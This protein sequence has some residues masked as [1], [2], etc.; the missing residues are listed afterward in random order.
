M[1][2]KLYMK[3]LSNGM[4]F[5]NEI[6]AKLDKID[7]HGA[8]VN[9][10][11]KIDD[12]YLISFIIKDMNIDF[13]IVENEIVVKRLITNDGNIFTDEAT[14]NRCIDWSNFIWNQIQLLLQ[15]DFLS[16]SLKE[17]EN[18]AKN[19][20]DQHEESDVNKS[21]ISS[22]IIEE[23]TTKGYKE[24]YAVARLEAQ[25]EMTRYKKKIRRKKFLFV[26]LFLLIA[27]IG[28]TVSYLYLEE[29]LVIKRRILEHI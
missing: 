18:D 11:E 12:T 9:E 16:N 26:I 6:L 13:Q 27:V 22:K 20:S 24:G 28:I 19:K 23:A 10:F 14:L 8:K 2:T 7:L 21:E 4:S 3:G 17:I 1:K 5:E 29:I 25:E 15:K